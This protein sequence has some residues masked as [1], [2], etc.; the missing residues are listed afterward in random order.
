MPWNVENGD[1]I[2]REMVYAGAEWF[3]HDLFKHINVIAFFGRNRHDVGEI[4]F[5]ADFGDKRQQIV[6]VFNVVDFIN[7]E[8]H[9]RFGFAQFV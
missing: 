5:A 3:A 7:G 9:R 4:K 8:H 6:L 1:V 2:F